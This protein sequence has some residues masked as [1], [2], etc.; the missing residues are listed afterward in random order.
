MQFKDFSF[1]EESEFKKMDIVLLS[2]F[3]VA[4][5]VVMLNVL[6]AIVSESYEKSMSIAKPMFWSSRFFLI[7]EVDH[8]FTVMRLK[9]FFAVLTHEFSWDVDHDIDRIVESSFG[10]NRKVH[11]IEDEATVERLRLAV[12]IQGVKKLVQKVKDHQ[13]R[14]ESK[15][16]DHIKKVQKTLKESTEMKSSEENAT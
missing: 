16:S 3:T 11:F 12:E 6:I 1:G 13:K 5:T 14:T 9:H 10:V 7:N 8:T 15:L 4:M 2:L